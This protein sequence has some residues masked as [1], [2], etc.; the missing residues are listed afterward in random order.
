MLPFL[1]TVALTL[2]TRQAPPAGAVAADPALAKVRA[3]ILR[4]AERRDFGL[5]LPMLDDHVDLG[6]HEYSAR[7]DVQRLV[8]TWPEDFGKS[9]WDD[10]RDVVQSG[11]PDLTD[12]YMFRRPGI[13]LGF[14][15]TD[16]GMKISAIVRDPKP[17]TKVMPVDVAA[18]DP[19]LADVRA[20]ILRA[21]ASR[22]FNMLLPILGPKIRAGFDDASYTPREFVAFQKACAVDI[23]GDFWRDLH[24]AIGLG[25]VKEEDEGVVAP[26]LVVKL[27]DPEDTLAITAERVA[28]RSMPDAGAP[29]QS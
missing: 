25:M 15:A 20:Q 13:V 11:V 26:Y 6:V 1:M 5:L 18:S 21:V 27:P 22:D 24:D 8:Q 29:V 4:A 10:L 9:F 16:A 14:R 28:L 2:S 17:R 19:G 3:Q 12:K 23:C 7:R